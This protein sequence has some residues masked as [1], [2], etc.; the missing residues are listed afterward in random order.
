MV[1]AGKRKH[2]TA[3]VVELVALIVLDDC[4]PS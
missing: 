2:G 3:V 1:R 4:D